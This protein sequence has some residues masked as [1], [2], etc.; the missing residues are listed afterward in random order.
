MFLSLADRDKTIGLAA[1]RRF[2]DLGFRIVATAGTAAALRG[3]GIPI[4]AVVAKI[5]EDRR[6]WM[7]ST[8]SRRA[9]STWW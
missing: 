6:A 7:R 4:E 2:A 3:E 8:S 9:R 1:A 5:G